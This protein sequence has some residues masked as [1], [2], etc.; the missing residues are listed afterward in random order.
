MASKMQQNCV[1]RLAYA[2]KMYNCAVIYITTFTLIDFLVI[3]PLTPLATPHT[4]HL[5]TLDVP[6]YLYGW[7][8][9]QVKFKQKPFR[10]WRFT[11]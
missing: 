4:Y 10:T 8:D 2:N 11:H 5:L 6:R 1:N 9:D 3:P 7:A